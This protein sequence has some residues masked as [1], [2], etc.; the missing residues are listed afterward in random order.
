MGN[1]GEGDGGV[2]DR[3]GHTDPFGTA[4]V[5]TFLGEAVAGDHLARSNEFILGRAF[6]GR[7][8]GIGE[9]LTGAADGHAT[10]VVFVESKWRARKVG[11]LAFK[12][13]VSS[14][15]RDLHGPDFPEDLLVSVD[16]GEFGPKAGVVLLVDELENFFVADGCFA[17]FPEIEFLSFERGAAPSEEESVLMGVMRNRVVVGDDSSRRCGDG[18]NE[19]A[20]SILG[21]NA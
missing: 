6:A 11:L 19:S 8:V 1:E 17:M 15:R 13:D 12:I 21:I 18:M 5:S 16:V 20:T 9:P 4:V 10:V 7:G 14:F 3:T 2:I